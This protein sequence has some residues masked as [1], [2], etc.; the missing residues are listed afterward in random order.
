MVCSVY[1]FGGEN[2]ASDDRYP[3]S[4]QDHSTQPIEVSATSSG[5]PHAS[6]HSPVQSQQLDTSFASSTMELAMYTID[7]YDEQQDEIYEELDA[8]AQDDPGIVVGDQECMQTITIEEEHEQCNHLTSS[9]VLKSIMLVN[10]WAGNS[11]QVDLEQLMESKLSRCEYLKHIERRLVEGKNEKETVVP[12]TSVNRWSGWP[13]HA[14]W[15]LKG[16]SP[17]PQSEH[18]KHDENVRLRTN[19]EKADGLGDSAR[20]QAMTNR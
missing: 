4:A 19:G 11:R 14:G 17:I 13:T 8:A 16:G 1:Y 10:R 6:H 20:V 15:G 5:P 18:V 2:Y 9:S 12:T 7:V 3:H